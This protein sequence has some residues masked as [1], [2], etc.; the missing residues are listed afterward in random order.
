MTGENKNYDIHRNLIEGCRNNDRKAQVRLYDLYYKA[1]YNT[2]YRILNNPAEAEDIMQEA[3]LDAFRKLN[4]FKGTGSF[5]SWLKRIVVNKSLD[6]LRVR[7]ETESLEVE[8]IELEDTTQTDDSYAGNVFSRIEDV[9]RT[10]ETLPD[11]YRIVLSLHLFEG[12]DH[13]EIAEI[14]NISY[15]N[16]RTRYSRAKQRLLKEIEDQKAHLINPINN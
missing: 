9:A 8:E 11:R 16:A 15:N 14:L 7:K 1:M 12:Y 2:S 4:G 6:K 5:G 10:M 13:E 3:F